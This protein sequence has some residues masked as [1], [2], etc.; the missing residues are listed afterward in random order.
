M[1]DVV[2]MQAA[3]K[4]NLALA[5]GPPRPD[6]MH[7][8]CSWMVT[9]DFHDELEVTRL[10][11]D[12][13]SR[14]AILWHPDARRTSDI[15]W[16][17]TKDLAVRAHLALERH[18]GRRLPVQLKLEKRIP[19][20]SGLGG[21]SA[22]AAAMLH[23]VNELYELRLSTDEL[24]TIGA[25]LGS[26]VPFLVHGGSAIVEGLG[27][28]IARHDQPPELHPVLVLPEASCPTETVYGLFDENEPEPM[29]ADAVRELASGT[30][31]RP[32]PDGPFNDLTRAAL[33]AAPEL[34]ELIAS[35]SRLAERP[36]HLSGSG[37]AIFVLC[38]DPLH[39]EFLAGTIEREHG[40]PAMAVK[41]DPRHATGPV[42]RAE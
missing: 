42:V 26:D 13:F 2:T 3:A 34:A 35:I 7:P 17:I 14:Y 31:G 30:P 5:V 41:A 15:D 39:A 36:A 33:R 37:S 16:S 22:D 9:V 24:A 29:R 20:G 6:G 4:L 19:V 40:L 8:V 21:G 28:R 27:E 18:L 12:R 1:L 10:L 38:D 11:P 23:A 25:T 32:R